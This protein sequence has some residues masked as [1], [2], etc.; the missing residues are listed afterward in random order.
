[1]KLQT[2]TLIVNVLK[3]IRQNRKNHVSSISC[4]WCSGHWMRDIAVP[5][6]HWESGGACYR[7]ALS[8]VRFVYS[9]NRL[10]Q[11]LLAKE[12]NSRWPSRRPYWTSGGDDDTKRRRDN[13]DVLSQRL[14]YCFALLLLPCIQGLNISN[15]S[16]MAER[17]MRVPCG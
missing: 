7:R 6:P 8:C 10:A 14:F 1:M 5:G 9:Q 2:S 11:P 15:L 13:H 4:I 16:A 12:Q 17:W 3:M